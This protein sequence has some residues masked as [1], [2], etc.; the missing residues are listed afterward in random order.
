MAAYNAE[1]FLRQAVDSVLAEAGPALE[2]D[3]VVVDDG[4]ADRTG[5]IARS[6]GDRL[7][8]FALAHTGRP[9]HVR[10]YGL[11]QVQGDYVGFLDDDDYWLPGS[12][13]ARV[14]ALELQPDAGFAYGN[15]YVLEGDRVRLEF[16]GAHGPSGRVFA[17]L[18][19]HN[20]IQ[21]S[22]VLVRRALLEKTTGFHPDARG[23]EDYALW[24]QLAWHGQAVYLPQPLS[25]YR[26]RIG[27]LTAKPATIKVPELVRVVT[28]AA[29]RFGVSADQARD[30]LNP[31]RTWMAREDF[32]AGRYRDGMRWLWP[33]LRTRP[34]ST[35]AASVRAVARRSLREV[36]A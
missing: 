5:E 17:E 27:S 33:A 9:G 13:A 1:R 36:S 19:Q 28:E 14:D 4:S 31:L 21:T 34:A 2:V 35:L 26:K 20:F 10:N 16:D 8:Y 6:Y 25:V 29:E 23:P 11:R 3:L 18:F 30:R 12:L 22:T 32:R 15:L 7:R 24:L